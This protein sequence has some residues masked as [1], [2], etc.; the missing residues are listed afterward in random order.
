MKA[1]WLELRKD[2]IRSAELESESTE[3]KALENEGSCSTFEV[4]LEK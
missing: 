1:T 4:F 2:D 3:S